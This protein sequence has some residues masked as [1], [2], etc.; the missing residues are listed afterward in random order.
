MTNPHHS[1]HQNTAA[2]HGAHS[3]FQV[4][5]DLSDTL[6]AKGRRLEGAKMVLNLLQQFEINTSLSLALIEMKEKEN[7]DLIKTGSTGLALHCCS[8]FF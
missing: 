8:W 2:F 6:H 3:E 5:S 7:F 1:L 4:G